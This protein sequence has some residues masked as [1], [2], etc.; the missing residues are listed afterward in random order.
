MLRGF[1]VVVV[2]VVYQTVIPR[3]TLQARP[4]F[5]TERQ[6]QHICSSASQSG[7]LATHSIQPINDGGSVLRRQ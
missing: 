4:A 7:E 5:W 6:R 1:E 3:S 2:V